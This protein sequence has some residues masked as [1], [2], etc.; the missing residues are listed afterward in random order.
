MIGKVL[1]SSAVEVLVKMDFN[2]FE[3]NKNALKIGKYLKIQT[4][5]FD[6]LIA[7]IKSIK[8]IADNSGQDKYLLSA[9]PVGVRL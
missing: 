9:E 1:E 8:A 3:K 5:N 6:F 2:D 4:G 7:T